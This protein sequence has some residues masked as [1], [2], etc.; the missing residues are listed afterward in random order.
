[1]L[2]QLRF[3]QNLAL[4]SNGPA[5]LDDTRL[6][7]LRRVGIV[8]REDPIARVDTDGDRLAAVR[9]GTGETLPREALIVVTTRDVLGSFL[10]A[11]RNVA[12]DIIADSTLRTPD[13]DATVEAAHHALVEAIADGDTGAAVVATRRN[14]HATLVR[15]RGE[16]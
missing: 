8:I 14:V 9:F 11:L 10:G 15:L 12:E 1:M 3:T 7:Y 5:G 6:E 13:E 4:I 2:L 16:P